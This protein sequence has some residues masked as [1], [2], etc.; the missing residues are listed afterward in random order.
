MKAREQEQGSAGQA[1][2]IVRKGTVNCEDMHREVRG[3]THESES[4]GTEKYR[5]GL[6]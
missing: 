6:R 2:G 4:T 1:Q 5:T 3:Q